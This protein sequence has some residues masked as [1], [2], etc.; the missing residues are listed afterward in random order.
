MF[1]HGGAGLGNCG[2]EPTFTPDFWATL[3]P[4]RMADTGCRPGVPGNTNLACTHAGP[5]F[6]IV[7]GSAYDG[8][9]TGT[10]SRST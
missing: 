9:V 3:A 2:G 4:R 1:Y 5:G 7:V 10:G 6:T 8:G